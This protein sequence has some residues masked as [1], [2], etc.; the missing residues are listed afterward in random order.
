MIEDRSASF[1][2]LFSH[3][4]WLFRVGEKAL[5]RATGKARGRLARDAHS[6]AHYPIVAGVILFAVGTEELV[7]H[8]DVAMEAPSRWA[9]LGGLMLVLRHRE[10]L[11]QL[12]ATPS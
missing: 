10:E 2:E 9:F 12:R 4:D 1:V 5:K 11:S 3:F 8:P 7:A 6:V